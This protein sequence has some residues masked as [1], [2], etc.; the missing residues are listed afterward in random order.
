MPRL[1]SEMLKA[2]EPAFSHSIHELESLAGKPGIDI[3]LSHEIKQLFRQKAKDLGLDEN[4]TTLKELYFSLRHRALED[5]DRLAEI[6]GVSPDDSPK[7]M[8][9]KSIAYVKKRLG[10]REVWSLKVSTARKQLKDNPPKKMMKLYSIRSIDSALKR[11]QPALFYC[12][13]ALVEPSAWQTKYVAQASKLTNSDFD[14]Q[15]IQISLLADSRQRQLEKAGIKLNRLT[16]THYETAAIEVTLMNRRFEGD[17][18]FLV[19]SLFNHI[20][21]ILHLAAYYKYQ[22]FQPDF[23][24]KVEQIRA[25]GIIPLES[26]NWPFDWHTLLHATA[27]LGVSGLVPGGQDTHLSAED[28]L[29]PSVQQLAQ[30]DIWKQ[31]FAL[32]TDN[33]LTVSSNL[34]DMIINAINKY[35]AETAYVGNARDH[36]RRELF[37]RYLHHEPVHKKITAV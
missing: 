13:A 2:P 1:I 26:A 15:P 25:G 24:S 14:Y 4:D 6:I 36:L 7:A 27:E 23:F 16:Y 37:A 34:S 5:S 21:H 33:G 3:R 20:K 31:P 29:S 11:E 17:V 35:P 30:F 28:F 19:D 8:S 22:G 9:E 12:F 32:Y 10:K 18:L